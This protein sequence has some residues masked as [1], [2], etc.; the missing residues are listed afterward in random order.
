LANIEQQP[1]HHHIEWQ[2]A[3]GAASG[4]YFYRLEAGALDNSGKQFAETK[5]ML[6]LR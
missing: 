1:G 5:K 4:I 3:S 2:P 6:L